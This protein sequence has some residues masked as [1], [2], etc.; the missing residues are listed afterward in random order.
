MNNDNVGAIYYDA[1]IRTDDFIKGANKMDKATSDLTGNIEKNNEK[2]NTS[3][4][5]MGVIVGAVSGVVSSVFTRAIDTISSSV[6][7]AVKRVDTLNNATRTFQ[8]LGFSATDTA[9]AMKALNQ[10]I[11]GLPTSLDDGVRGMTALAATYGDIGKGQKV[12]SALNDAILGFGGSADSVNNAI[13]QLSQV[14]LDGPLDAQTWNS[15]RNSGLTPVLVAMS[16]DM[17]VSVSKLKEQFG[18]GTLKVKDFTDELIKLDNKG[19]GSMKSLQQIVRDSTSGIGTGIANAKTAVTRGIGNIIQAIGSANISSAI[20]NIGTGF[21]SV[22]KSISGSIPAILKEISPFT[23]RMGELSSRVVN[24]AEKVVSYFTPSIVGL[25]QALKTNLIPSVIE[26]IKRLEPLAKVVGG[27]TLFAFKSLIDMVSGLVSFISGLIGYITQTQS[28]FNQLTATVGGVVAAFVL[29]K[30]VLIA[31]NAISAISAAYAALTSTKYLLLNGV[32]IT[33]RTATVAQ[34]VAQLALNFAMSLNPVGLVV[35]GLALLTGAFVASTFQ[36]NNTKTSTDRLKDARDAAKVA[37]DNLKTSE[38]ALKGAQF[39]AEGA[40]LRAESAQKNYNEAVKNYGPDSLEARTALHDMKVAND[41]LATANENVK[42]KTNETVAA[43]Q[44][45]VKTKDTVVAALREIS[46]A[47]DSTAYS[48][49]NV[50]AQAQS[51]KNEIQKVQA[52]GGTVSAPTQLKAAGIPSVNIP[53][54]AGGGSVNANSPYFVGD[55]KDG[56]LNSTSELFVPS[57]SGSIMNSSALEKALR[58]GNSK[59]SGTKIE[60]NIGTINIADKMTADYFLRKLNGN[61]EI[62]SNGLTPAQKYA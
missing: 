48:L 51:A 45:I 59:S 52:A 57:S 14:P 56:S 62:V 12:F 30:A 27:V 34:T 23:D 18:D 40:S 25:Y 53:H 42:N 2:S 32:L 31:S 29:Y 16:K 39:D 47:T 41:D 6:E 35:A 37:T 22:L 55:N 44:E 15:L 49:A 24:I 11:Y 19:G 8:N 38:D 3:F 13:L 21:E 10:S 5:K 61:Q 58:T 33:T 46:G 54:R 4:G 43:Q 7:G 17:K 60:N 1:S 26:V 50:A 28:R 20:S 36:T 9:S